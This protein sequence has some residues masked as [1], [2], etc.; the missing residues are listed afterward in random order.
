MTSTNTNI[1]RFL[2]RVTKILRVLAFTIALIMLWSASTCV[3]GQYNPVQYDPNQY[4]P[5][6]SNPGQLQPLQPLN[7]V[8]PPIQNPAAVST[9]GGMPVTSGPV[10]PIQAENT[11]L[12]ESN[13]VF[14]GEVEGLAS[15]MQTTDPTAMQNFRT[16]SSDMIPSG[17]EQLRPIEAEQSNGQ[18]QSHM[19][20][21]PS[22]SGSNHGMFGAGTER[23]LSEINDEPFDFS[24]IMQQQKQAGDDVLFGNN[25]AAL[26]Q[27]NPFAVGEDLQENL[28]G[29]L[30]D[31]TGRQEV[32]T[33]VENLI[34]DSVIIEGNGK[35][36]Q[37][38]IRNTIKTMAGYPF[39]LQTIQE[40]ARTLNQMGCFF[41][42]TPRYQRKNNN[43][44]VVRF[45]LVERPMF[46]SVQFVGN[47]KIRKRT[48][49]EQVGIKKGDPVDVAMVLQ[50]REK[51]KE[52]YR[53]E[54][55]ERASVTVASGDRI[56]DRN[57]VYIINEGVKQRVLDTEIVGSRFLTPA[58]LKTYIE[59][60]PGILYIIGGEFSREKLDADVEKILEFYQR[61][62]FLDIQVDRTFE[63]TNGY[64]GISE[65]GSWIKVK[66]IVSEG[67]RYKINRIKF[68]G[69]KRFSNEEL[70]KKFKLKSGDYYQQT[71]MLLDEASIGQKYG[72]EGLLLTRVKGNVLLL[73]DK[74][75]EIDITYSIRESGSIIASQ[76]DIDFAGDVAHTRTSTLLKYLALSNIKPGRLVTA[77]MIRNA[78]KTVS[79]SQFLN[80]N[81]SEGAVPRITIV[82]EDEEYMDSDEM[83][84]Q[85]LQDIEELTIRGQSSNGHSHMKAP[86]G[87][88]VNYP[89]YYD[90]SA[91]PGVF[92]PSATTSTS[93][94]QNQ[95]LGVQQGNYAVP[96]QYQSYQAA[97]YSPSSQ[98]GTVQAGT[99]PSLP[100][101]TNVST[102]GP[103]LGFIG[104]DNAAPYNPGTTNSNTGGLFSP[105]ASYGGNQYG[106]SQGTTSNDPLYGSQP[107]TVGMVDNQI[108]PATTSPSNYYGENNYGS[109]TQA[110]GLF[111]TA[112]A[113]NDTGAPGSATRMNLDPFADYT[114]AKV[115]FRVQ[116]GKTGNVT[117]GVSLN[118]DSGLVGR[119]AIEERNFDWRKLPTNPWSLAGW[120]NAFR[121]AGQKF[122][123]EAMPGQNYQRYQV[124]FQEPLL[125]NTKFSLGLNGFYYTRYYDE[126]RENRT[127]GGV[128]LGRSWTDR[129]STSLSFNGANIKVYDPYPI[130]DLY[131]VLGNNAQYAFGLSATY[132][133]RDNAMMPT[134]GGTLTVSAEQVLGTSKFMRGGYDIRRYLI[135]PGTRRGDNSG[136]W[137]IGLRS[138]ANITE[139]STPIYERYYAGGY[140]TIRG[141]E[142][143][144][145]TP[146][147]YGYGVGGNFEFY[148]SIELCFPISAD[149]NFRG[150]V[151]LDT[152]TVEKS[153]SK[154]E[155]EYRVAPGFGFRVNIP[156]MGPVP[157]AF[158]FAFPINK[159]HG[160]ITEMFSFN[161]GWVR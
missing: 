35:I 117:V 34:V 56:D 77:D 74:P 121:G 71:L 149:D 111:P 13:P 93:M 138:A 31:L 14:D 143:R 30:V 104:Q 6:Q 147:W 107:G 142:Y 50:G 52:Y 141:F 16:G 140:S 108:I 129:F 139:K 105:S 103:A 25:G 20:S 40:D 118:S 160:D 123:L 127:G 148:N 12:A 27:N 29:K 113:Y 58:R 19:L 95:D 61:H 119:F 44:V 97:P 15:R 88:Q 53:S 152:G 146:R 126:W 157:I 100:V 120:R 90:T 109:V 72:N 145:V 83:I 161:M 86:T 57:V 8:S 130:P 32:D 55:F 51:L 73:D 28:G 66:F 115:N 67:P 23:S 79:R 124:S 22:T 156:M 47:Y 78:E 7:T 96:E 80:A 112:G 68:V 38:T 26:R 21:T 87:Y 144:G 158:D 101:N 137:V 133:T 62:G 94:P 41:S 135:I 75:G 159:Q 49:A 64:L 5:V 110:S 33:E 128:T 131:E 70:G 154:W 134:E 17:I 69:N 125:W 4:V 43:L 84:D 9:Y 76:I 18:M 46:H 60:K 102:P 24:A 116:E 1:S 132:D 42:V 36:P 92:S 85:E 82:P 136:G 155:N 63:D 150:V 151:F 10:V 39:R 37:H 89:Q 59:S 153:I 45:E 48:L 81:P 98:F 91:Q 11:R 114:R 2:S 99:V 65:P 106:T 122:L 3:M 54:G